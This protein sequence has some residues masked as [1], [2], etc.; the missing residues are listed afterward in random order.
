MGD[1]EIFF[2]GLQI[3]TG[4]IIT[5]H[6]DS[7][8]AST[9]SLLERSSVD[10]TAQPYLPPPTPQP[11]DFQRHQ[12]VFWGEGPGPVGENFQKGRGSLP[13]ETDL[14][15][16]QEVR[17]K[18]GFWSFPLWRLPPRVEQR[19]SYL[20]AEEACQSGAVYCVPMCAGLCWVL[21]LSGALCREGFKVRSSHYGK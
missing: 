14:P 10:T 12:G 4:Q 13:E 1:E 17:G 2:K 8:G 3:V 5:R 11:C 16:L 20:P 6:L 9:R 18:G 7:A 15:S 19:L 21:C